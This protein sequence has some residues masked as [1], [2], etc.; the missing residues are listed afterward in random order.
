M[1]SL[2]VVN[3][4]KIYIWSNDFHE[5]VHVHVSKGRPSPNA[6]KIW[7][8][9]TGGALLARNTSR[10]P[11]HELDLLLDFIQ[12]ASWTIVGYWCKLFG[13]VSYYC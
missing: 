13:A 3:G 8:T 11:K 10:I 6:T 5:P 2:F 1:P 7:I 4:Y 12:G 9:Q